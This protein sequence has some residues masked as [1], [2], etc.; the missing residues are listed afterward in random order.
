[1]A[2]VRLHLNLF[3][4]RKGNGGED[5]LSDW[6]VSVERWDNTIEECFQYTFMLSII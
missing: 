2:N 6:D 3:F 4:E 5:W 1:M